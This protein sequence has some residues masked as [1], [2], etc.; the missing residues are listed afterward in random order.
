[1][2]LVIDKERR[3]ARNLSDALSYMGFI[4]VGLTP[5]EALSEISLRYSAVIVMNP[6]TLADK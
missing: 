6:A 2:I 5:S 4:S 1:M 3:T